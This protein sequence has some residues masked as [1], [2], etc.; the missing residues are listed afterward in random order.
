MIL[1]TASAAG[2]QRDHEEGRV[3]VERDQLAGADRPVEREARAEPGHEH[4]EEAR[5]EHLRRVER[6]LRQ[7]DAHAGAADLLRA[8]AVAVEERLLAADPAQHA[9]A[10]GRV[11]AERGQLADLLALLALAR[12]QRL[13]HVPSSEHEHRHADQH[14]EPEHDRRREQDDGDDDVRDDRAGR[15][16]P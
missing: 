16:A 4:D 14:D 3:A 10:R 15:G 9:Q 5:H 11:G 13:D 1:S 2:P 8:V 12:L 6:R 7:R